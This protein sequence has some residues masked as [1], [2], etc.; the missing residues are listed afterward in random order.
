MMKSCCENKSSELVALRE[1]QK[2]VL[3]IVLIINTLMFFIEFIFGY[4]SSSTALIAD[5]LDMLGDATVYAF[6]LY[7]INKSIKWKATAALLKGI[8]ITIF[9]LYVLAEAISKMMSDIVPIAETMGIVGV[10]ALIANS[11]CLILLLKHRDDDINMKSTWICSRNDII[12]NTGV[13]A[14]ALLVSLLN[15]KWPDVIVGMSIAF[16]FLK[17]SF[18]ILRE[19]YGEL[20]DAA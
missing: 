10:I 19:S 3:V 18:S 8:I 2:N 13:L 20:K 6:S 12:A 14:A 16:V 1:K 11:S 17:S 15:S 4:L 9:G 5:S 7:V